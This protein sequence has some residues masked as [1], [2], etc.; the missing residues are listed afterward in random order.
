M[1]IQFMTWIGCE[2]RFQ[3]AFLYTACFIVWKQT[4]DGE[5]YSVVGSEEKITTIEKNP[6]DNV[7]IK[8]K[9]RANENGLLLY[10]F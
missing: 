5:V 6:K 4:K 1:W 7:L 10:V 2:N 8:G 3:S 9:I